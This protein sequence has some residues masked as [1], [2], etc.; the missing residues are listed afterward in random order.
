MINKTKKK[1]LDVDFI[2]EQNH[3]LTKEEQ[4]EISAFIQ[5]LK[6]SR[7]PVNKGRIRIGE[8]QLV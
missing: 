1:E 4:L 3:P 6:A 2:G 8:K 5:K 7:R